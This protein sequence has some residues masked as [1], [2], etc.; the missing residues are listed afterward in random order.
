MSKKKEVI[1][2]EK[3]KRTDHPFKKNIYLIS[4][5]WKISKMRVIYCFLSYMTDF[6]C[7]AFDTIVFTQYIF[8]SGSLNM[9]FRDVTLFIG[10]TML[11]YFVNYVVSI[12]GWTRYY[13]INDALLVR[14]LNKAMFDKACNV[15]ISCF[16]DSEFFNKY[17]KASNEVHQ[18]SVSALEDMSCLVAATLSTVYVIYTMFTINVWVGLLMFL[19]LISNLTLGRRAKTLHYDRDMS[20]LPFKRRFGYVNRVYYL[21]DYAKEIRLSG[22]SG[23]LR[24]E[25][26]TAVDNIKEVNRKKWFPLFVYTLIDNIICFPLLF[27]GSWLLGLFLCMVTKSITLPEFVVLCSAAVSATWMIRNMSGSINGIF[28]NALYADNI[29]AF[30][31]YKEKIPEDSPGDPVPERVETL[32]VRN[33]SFTYNGSDTPALENVN[34]TLRAGEIA[35]LVGHNG[36]GKST[37]VKLLMRLYDPSEGVIL[38]NGKDIREYEL[39]AYRALVGSTFQDFKVFS[40]SVADNVLV[41]NTVDGDRREAAI[42]ALK[43]SGVHDRIMQLDKKEETILTKEFDN[44]G[45]ILSGGEAQKVCISRAFVKK[46]SILLLDEPSSALDP[47]AEHDMYENFVSL[48]KRGSSP[49]ISVFISHRLS[50]ATVADMVYLLKGG[51]IIESG[52]H[53]ELIKLDGEYASM[54]RKQAENYLFDLQEEGGAALS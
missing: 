41:G 47:F 44:D 16:E 7:W 6:I 45:A 37:L 20:F 4:M 46:S 13:K 31:E 26:N 42:E 24:K 23:V 53:K 14:E 17:T 8:G 9:S 27:E 10:F 28:E 51:R 36:S 29:S 18:R 35:S 43:M 33:V 11:L 54:F 3:K 5:I 25:Y 21:S 1:K 52:T 49:K 34:L 39:R 48:C 19:P 15:D 22:I 38:L 2:P 50:S 30:M 12:Y 32:E 40:M